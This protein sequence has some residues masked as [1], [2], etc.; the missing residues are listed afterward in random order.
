[1]GAIIL[2]NNGNVGIGTT[3]PQSKL[4]VAGTITAQ[5]VKVT[6]SGWSDFVFNENYQLPTLQETEKYILAHKHLPDIPSA[7]EILKDG[8]DL[9]EINKKLLQKIEELTLHL[10]HQQKEILELRDQVKKISSN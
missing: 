10:I 3:N 1:M 6:P 9:G 2:L 7:K 4:A 5:R 8:V